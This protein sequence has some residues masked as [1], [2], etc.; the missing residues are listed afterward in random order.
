MHKVSITPFKVIGISVRTS[1]SNG[2][3]AQDIPQLW[4]R[5]I[6]EGIAAKIPN[7]LDGRIFC[8]YTNYEGDHNLPYDT[9]L[10]CSVSSLKDIPEGMT[11]LEIAGGEYDQVTVK[12]DLTQGLVY[13]AW[14]NIWERQLDRKY[15]ADFEI[16][17]ERA[18]DRHHAVVDILVG[19]NR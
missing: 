2:K 8:I 18:Q 5:F 9:V 17:D 7:K 14:E 6:V 3:A 16:Y 10:G 15:A 1:N 12:G 4:S 11:G 19:L 13:R